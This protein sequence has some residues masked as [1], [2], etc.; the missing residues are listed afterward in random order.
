MEDRCDLLIVDCLQHDVIRSFLSEK[1]CF[2]PTD[3]TTIEDLSH[4]LSCYVTE[5]DANNSD[6]MHIENSIFVRNSRVLFRKHERN[7]SGIQMELDY[8]GFKPFLRSFLEY[9]LPTTN[10]TSSQKEG[11]YDKFG[12]YISI[13]PISRNGSSRLPSQY[14]Y[15]FVNASNNSE[16]YNNTIQFI[17]N[18]H[19]IE[20]MPFTADLNVLGINCIY[21]STWDNISLL[22]EIKLKVVSG[23]FEF[24]FTAHIDKCGEL[25]DDTTIEVDGQIY[26]VPKSSFNPFKIDSSRNDFISQGMS[27][28]KF[29]NTFNSIT[30]NIN[31][32]L[33]QYKLYD[34]LVQLFI[35]CKELKN[36]ILVL[37]LIYI[38]TD[39]DSEYSRENSVISTS[40]YTVASRCRL[41]FV[42]CIVKFL[43]KQPVK[44][45]EIVKNEALNKRGRQ[46]LRSR[47]RDKEVKNRKGGGV[48]EP[49]C[50][51]YILYIPLDTAK[52]N[53]IISSIDH[54]IAH[55]QITIDDIETAATSNFIIYALDTHA[56]ESCPDT[57]LF[58]QDIVQ[59]IK[60]A[61]DTLN[62]Y[63]DAVNFDDSMV[64]YDD[65]YV[66]CLIAYP[67]F[68]KKNNKQTHKP[69]LVASPIR[70]LFQETE[71]G[72][73]LVHNVF[74]KRT[75]V[76][77]LYSKM[78]IK[79]PPSD[80]D[81]RITCEEDAISFTLEPYTS[82]YDDIDFGNTQILVDY[83]FGMFVLY[84]EYVGAVLFDE[85]FISYIIDIITSKTGCSYPKF[86]VEFEKFKGQYKL[87]LMRK[88][89]LVTKKS[90]L[91]ETREFKSLLNKVLIK[92]YAYLLIAPCSYNDIH[93]ALL[94]TQ[95]TSYK[96]LESENI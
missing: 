23:E 36:T 58:L 6:D 79:T 85:I 19:V 18:E 65:D 30:S 3:D 51:E 26:V 66:S 56:R 20:R 83:I 15:A 93:L 8:V 22:C 61:N 42:A 68:I 25:H 81:N 16:P 74:F 69:V 38:F 59:R 14:K 47:T 96:S 44:K 60:E 90:I 89:D 17:K 62:A 52:Q 33:Q 54:A 21:V 64:L 49:Y 24:T 70:Q 46:M 78:G 80:E 88:N 9:I 10:N 32:C 53:I 86:K 67:P 40:C 43:R 13:A 84:F 76:E 92:K 71:S 2:V 73:V 5:A 77:K 48:D 39:K 37:V 63:K 34:I 45:C 29:I 41:N 87:D 57:V 75:F 94:T 31:P 91:E 4:T 50:S 82:P 7:N 55:N 72:L 28:P 95:L 11:S 27:S 1:L 35:L 12:S